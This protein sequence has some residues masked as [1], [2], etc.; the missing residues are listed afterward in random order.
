MTTPQ[1]PDSRASH[2]GSPVL[3]LFRPEALAY[4]QQ[5]FY[6]D[7][8]L[9]RP[10]SLTLLTGFVIA[11]TA[12]A[13]ALLG[14]GHYTEKARLPISPGSGLSANQLELHVPSRWQGLVQ[15]GA[16]LA[17]RCP[18]CP[19]SPTETATVMSVSKPAPPATADEVT[20]VL[21]LSPAAA[22]AFELNHPQQQEAALEAELPLGRKP[23]VQWF[24]SR[25]AN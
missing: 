9:I 11:L 13:I 12:A 16:R 7:I 15:P 5:K 3:P 22:Q 17:V 24:F 4:Q 10:L 19:S 6:G 1:V 25:P 21:S 2:N 23:L 8:I 18:R 14:F 20:A